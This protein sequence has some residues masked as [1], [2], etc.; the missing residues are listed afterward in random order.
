LSNCSP[1]P[2][3]WGDG[4][5]LEQNNPRVYLLYAKTKWCHVKNAKQ[6]QA[7]GMQQALAELPANSNLGR[8]RGYTGTCGW[9]D[10]FFKEQGSNRVYRLHGGSQWCR[11][12]DEGQMNAYGGFGLVLDIDANS[13]L[14]RGRKW[15][16]ICQDP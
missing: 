5:Y 7:Y 11:V 9:P 10:G 2:K 14:G 12:R 15:E 8:N 3:N 16:P 6:L 1:P 4:F 13:D